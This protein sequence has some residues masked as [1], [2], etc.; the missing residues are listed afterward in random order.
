MANTNLTRKA[1][2][3]QALARQQAATDAVNLNWSMIRNGDFYHLPTVE[4]YQDLQ[5]FCMRAL[6][7]D[8]SDDYGYHYQQ[9]FREELQR[10]L[11]NANRMPSI[12][13]LTQ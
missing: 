13:L 3:A 12:T 5:R 6:L 7:T 11:V 1:K 2:F 8:T 10:Q 9:G 4:N